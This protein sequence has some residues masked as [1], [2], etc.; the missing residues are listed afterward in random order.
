MT[1]LNW[2]RTWNRS[3]TRLIEPLS[4]LNMKKTKASAPSS[5]TSI[6]ILQ[7]M[8]LAQ[9]WMKRKVQE[10]SK[11]WEVLKN[12][13]RECRKQERDKMRSSTSK[14][15]GDLSKTKTCHLKVPSLLLFLHK[16]EQK[17][18]ISLTRQLH[19]KSWKIWIFLLQWPHLVTTPLALTNSM[20]MNKT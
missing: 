18:K 19:Q 11:T 14:P 13:L 12:Q 3:R 2:A 16:S 6:R 20:L 8:L 5:H 7:S 17:Q 10:A 15:L 1:C 9:F 4:K